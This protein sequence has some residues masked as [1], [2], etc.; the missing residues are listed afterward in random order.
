MPITTRT[1]AQVIHFESLTPRLV[2]MCKRLFSNLLCGRLPPGKKVHPNPPKEEEVAQFFHRMVP[3][4]DL[5][6]FCEGLS[7][8]FKQLL[9]VLKANLKT[10]ATTKEDVTHIQLFRV[11]LKLCRSI[12]SQA[13]IL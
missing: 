2:F 11:R 8:F 12:L 5:S 1:L 7:L 13:R 6:E 9:L 3:V 10:K 4:K